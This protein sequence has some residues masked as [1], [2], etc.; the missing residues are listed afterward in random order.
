[1]GKNIIYNDFYCIN[2]GSRITLPRKKGH[3]HERSHFK[4]CYCYNCKH[5][6]NFYEV[7]DYDDLVYFTEAFSAGDFAELAKESIKAN[8]SPTGLERV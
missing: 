1:M 8:L 4:K 5:T 6:L 2:C 7:K 3:Q